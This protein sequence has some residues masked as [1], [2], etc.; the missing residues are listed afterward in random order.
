M[1]AACDDRYQQLDDKLNRLTLK[2]YDLEDENRVLKR[3]VGNLESENKVRKLMEDEL[4]GKNHVLKLR[5]DDLEE[6]NQVLTQQFEQPS[7]APQSPIQTVTSPVTFSQFTTLGC[8]SDTLTLSCPEGRKIFTTSAVYGQYAFTCDA[9]CCAP[10]PLDDCTELVEENRPEDWLVIKLLCD[11]QTSCEYEYGG[12]VISQCQEG[13]VADYLQIFYDCV[14]HDVSQPVGFSAKATGDA[15][16]E[17]VGGEIVMYDSVLSN[18]GDHYNSATSTFI[19]PYDGI[20]LFNVNLQSF[21]TS[22]VDVVMF[23]NDIAL[24]EAMAFNDGA[25]TNGYPTASSLVVTWCNSG[26]VIWV[27]CDYAE[28]GGVL[29]SSQHNVFSGYLLDVVS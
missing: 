1:D 19:C 27:K 23:R 16:V 17:Y 28:N 24:S 7:H 8:L 2:L 10:H 3:R 11:N 29:H 15:D 9:G 14:P 18:F 22:R 26:D 20:Y 12:S 6:K 5:V 25:G 4:K 13:Y 21:Y